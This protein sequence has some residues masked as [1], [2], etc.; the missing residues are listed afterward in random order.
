MPVPTS[1]SLLRRILC[2]KARGAVEQTASALC[3]AQHALAA[4]DSYLAAAIAAPRSHDTPH[5][6]LPPAG[7]DAPPLARI[8]GRK[9]ARCA[10]N[11]RRAAGRTDI[12]VCPT[13]DAAIRASLAVI[14]ANRALV[15]AL[16]LVMDAGAVIDAAL[17]DEI[18]KYEENAAV[19]QAFL[20]VPKEPT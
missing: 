10:R 6:R 7:I 9:T 18:I 5:H 20:P 19:G 17:A 1:S 13:T 3:V 12:N 2:A 16:L 14:D 4:A 11:E 15:E 8:A